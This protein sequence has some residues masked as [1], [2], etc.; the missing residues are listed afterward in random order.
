MRQCLAKKLHLSSFPGTIDALYGISTPRPRTSG[1]FHHAANTTR[2]RENIERPF[3]F[4]QQEI[5]RTTG[6]RF[7]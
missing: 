4:Y 1:I 7:A 5:R 3:L 2:P 6:I